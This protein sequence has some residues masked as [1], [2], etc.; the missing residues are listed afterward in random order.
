MRPLKAYAL[1]P[2]SVMLALALTLAIPTLQQQFKFLL[3]FFAVS[4]S[5]AAGLWPGVLATLLSVAVAD[6]FLMKP[7]HTFGITDPRELVPLCLFAGV[8]FGV[9][10]I[11]HR[12]HLSEEQSRAAA[13][14]IDSSADAIIR[15][16]S[17]YTVLSWNKAAERAYGYTPEEAIGKPVSLIVPPEYMEELHR[18][19]DR[20]HRGESVQSHETV[21][22][23]K[24][25]TRLEVALTVSPVQDRDGNIVAMST[26]QRDIRERKRAEE[27]LRESHEKLERQTQQLQLLAEMGSLLQAS[28]TPADAYAVAARFAQK[29]IPA[30]SG[31]VY[32]CSAS[33]KDLEIASH[34][35]ESEPNEP[36]YLGTDSCWALRTGRAHFVKDTRNGLLCHHLPSPLPSS[37]LCVPM[38]ALGELV[39]LLH[40]QF[41]DNQIVLPEETL[42]ESVENPWPASSIADR[43]A[44]A[45]ANMQLRE[46]LRA[47][48]IRD[49]LTGW[50]NRRYMEETLE[51]EIF[52][53]SRNERPLSVIMLDVDNFKEF[54]DTFGH[55]AGD[56]VLQNLCQTLKDH[57]R[58]E[59]VAC[60]YGGDEFVIVLPDTSAELASRRADE[61]R[62][63]LAEMGAHYQGKSGL[64]TVSIG[65]AAFPEDGAT[66]KELLRASDIALFHAKGEGRDRVRLHSKN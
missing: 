1:A 12:L 60:R 64:L 40:I 54:N 18:L 24:N 37:Y 9:T 14:L 13:A 5:A 36:G 46:A 56:T 10:W 41:D 43:L 23:T 47:Q 21:R 32:A 50:F 61:L 20:I 65:I 8:G 52:R 39:G 33:T 59:D 6:Y 48:S 3:F 19:N 62:S 53:A 35:G 26:I 27:A 51:R 11:T 7:S 30:T 29:L 58:N 4:A 34:W 15:T 63:A 17:D 31:S 16:S 22:T 57:V 55:E 45:V 66:L 2:L 28:S 42:G 38:T 25:G 44:H 49:P